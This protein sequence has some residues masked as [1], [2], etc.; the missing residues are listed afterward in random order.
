MPTDQDEH[1]GRYCPG[2]Q[3][4]WYPAFE[5]VECPHFPSQTTMRQSPR[6]ES[7]AERDAREIVERMNF[8]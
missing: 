7:A 4:M 8:S 1:S 5:E 2:C 6:Q 3:Q